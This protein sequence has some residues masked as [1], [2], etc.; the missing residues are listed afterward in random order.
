M[1]VSTT[2]HNSKIKEALKKLLILLLWIGVWQVA[3]MAVRQEILLVSPAQVFVRL[4]EL[5]FESYFWH[6]T[7]LS[8]MRIMVG[9][10]LAVLAGTLLA[11]I[12]TKV[13]FIN[14][15]LYPILSLIK[16]TPVASFIILALVWIG[17]DNVP[18]FISFLMVLPMIWANVSAGIEGVD[19]KLLEVAKVFGFSRQKT[20]KTI[21]VPSI[22]PTFLS[23]CTT[24]LGFAWKSGI[25]AEVIS[26]PENSIG[27]HLFN[28]KIYIETID[29]FAWTIV[30]VFLSVIIEKLL[31]NIINRYG[32]RRGIKV[33]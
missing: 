2:T 10:I 12:T 1:T 15:L 28:A 13:R 19:K 24:G 20:I 27:T 6:S 30:V 32:G 7:L 33:D 16:A 3:Y 5:I 17:R 26:T 8:L 25:A 31:V 14:D 29:L 22:T 4:F 9:Y 18:T 11:V 23:A 21:Y